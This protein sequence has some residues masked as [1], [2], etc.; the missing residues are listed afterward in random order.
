[1]MLGMLPAERDQFRAQ[2]V[3]EFRR[4]L[5][6]ARGE[7]VPAREAGLV[8]ELHPLELPRIRAVGQPQ[9]GSEIAHV[10]VLRE[11]P[12]SRRLTEVTEQPFRV[13]HL[14]SAI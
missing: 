14:A 10:I 12:A 6:V 9:P 5:P 3:V 11:P 13:R 7:R 2:V 8:V 4:P 1:M